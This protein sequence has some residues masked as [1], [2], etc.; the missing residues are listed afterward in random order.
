MKKI[1]TANPGTLEDGDS[2]RNSDETSIDATEEF[3]RKPFTSSSSNRGGF[4]GINIKNEMIKHVTATGAASSL[5]K[6]CSVFSVVQDKWCICR[7]CYPITGVKGK[8]NDKKES[9]MRKI[10]SEKLTRS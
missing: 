10:G 5:G 8:L 6:K 4:V 9:F 2:P 7:W 1:D 3:T